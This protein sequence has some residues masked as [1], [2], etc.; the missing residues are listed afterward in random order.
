MHSSTTRGGGGEREARARQPRRPD[1]RE[2]RRSTHN[3][4]HRE[5]QRRQARDGG[6]HQGELLPGRRREDQIAEQLARQ[7]RVRQQGDEDEGGERQ[8]PGDRPGRAAGPAGGKAEADGQAERQGRR[9]ARRQARQSVGR[10]E[11]P[12]QDQGV[13]RPCVDVRIELEG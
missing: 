10:G 7:A 2:E 13:A 5:A 11:V 12:G 9:G 1:P 6:R 4:S 8:H 3:R